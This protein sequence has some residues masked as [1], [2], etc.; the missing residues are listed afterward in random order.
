[1]GILARIPAFF[2]VPTLHASR[3]NPPS[4]RSASAGG[5]AERRGGCVP[6]EDRGNEENED[7]RRH[8]PPARS[9]RCR[10]WM[11]SLAIRSGPALKIMGSTETQPR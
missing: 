11:L 1:M 2:Q 9:H 6:T 8:V 5:D 10:Y 7:D 4:R 3:G